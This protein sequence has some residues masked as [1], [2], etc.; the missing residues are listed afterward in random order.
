MRRCNKSI[1][2]CAVAFASSMLLLVCMVIVDTTLQQSVAIAAQS[3][4]PTTLDPGSFSQ[5]FIASAKQAKA[6]VVNISSA[7]QCRSSGPVCRGASIATSLGEPLTTSR[8][9]GRLGKPLGECSLP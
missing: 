1:R 4:F 5:P 9:E 6:S 8:D 3:A 2:N 7:P